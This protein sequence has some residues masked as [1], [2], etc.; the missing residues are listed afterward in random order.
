MIV[1]LVKQYKCEDCGLVTN[2]LETY[3][4][5]IGE[6]FGFPAYETVYLC[7]HCGSIDLK[8]Y[9]ESEDEEDE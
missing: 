9:Y 8:E 3:R 1:Q 7:P 4:E 6:C 2:E 5:N